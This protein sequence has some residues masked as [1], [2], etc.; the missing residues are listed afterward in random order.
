MA[1]LALR[2]PASLGR[3]FSVYLHNLINFSIFQSHIG[4]I[5]LKHLIKH[6]VVSLSFVMLILFLEL[7]EE[8]TEQEKIG[9]HKR[10][11]R[12]VLQ[13]TEE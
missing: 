1:L 11:N 9:A 13:M 2:N 12:T 8:V 7:L 5:K 6:N 10:T 4:K 3:K